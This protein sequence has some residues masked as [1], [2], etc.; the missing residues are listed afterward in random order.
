MHSSQRYLDNP[1]FSFKETAIVMFNTQLTNCEFATALNQ[2]Y[3][4]SLTRIDDLV[5][6]ITSY[7]CFIFHHNDLHLS[8]VLLEHPADAPASAPFDYYEKMLL[9]RGIDAW[10]FQQKIYEDLSIQ[11]PEPPSDELLLHHNWVLA[12]QLREG[13]FETATFN[14][15]G[16][17][18][19]P[20]TSLHLGPDDTMPK[21]L[22][23]YL[24]KL[25]LFLKEVF[26]L[27]ECHLSNPEEYTI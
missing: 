3:R 7:P 21:R 11:Q 16:N 5:V 26:T 23:T 13:V 1:L 8:Y 25:Q 15:S 17:N 12:N 27:F 20:V 2:A 18:R 19:S 10:A 24:D 22:H 4:L 6:G 9:I 14:L